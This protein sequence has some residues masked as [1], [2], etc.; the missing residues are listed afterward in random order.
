MDEL[1]I[2]LRVAYD[3]RH[4]TYWCTVLVQ[5]CGREKSLQRH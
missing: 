2:I 5:S 1:M 4:I 3:Q